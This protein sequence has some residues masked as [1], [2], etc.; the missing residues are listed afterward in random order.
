MSVNIR[1]AAEI[2]KKL[3]ELY[4]SRKSSQIMNNAINKG[5]ER[6]ENNL[7]KEMGKHKDSGYTAD[8]VVRTNARNNV[9]GR[10]AQVG[11]SAYKGRASIVHLGEFGYSIKGLRVITPAFGAIQKVAEENK[12]DYLEIVRQEVMKLL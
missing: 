2:E 5:A 8:A 10:V 9:S 1:G 6:V 3:N 7:R 11:F 4:S 12:Q